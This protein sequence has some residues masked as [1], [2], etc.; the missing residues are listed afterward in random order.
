MLTQKI[1]LPRH[2]LKIAAAAG[3]MTATA[4]PVQAEQWRGWNIQPPGY[5]NTVALETFASE[6]SERTEGR[7]EPKVYNNGVLGAQPDAI[8]QTRNGALDFGNFN[9]GPMGPMVPAA[10]VLSLPF[11]F[12]S[13]ESMYKL[14]D[15][16]IGQRFANAMKDQGL[17]ALGWFGAGSRSLYNSDHPIE[18]P[19]DLK[20]MKIR[21]MNND[22][23]VD[24][25][26]ALGGNAT[27]MAASEVYQSLTTGVIDGAENNIPTY[28][29]SGHYE[30]ANYFSL[31]NH[32]VIPECLCVAKSSWDELSEQDRNSVKAAAELAV[33][34]QRKLWEERTTAGRKKV[35]DAGAKI[36][37]VSNKAAF[38]K[39]MKPVYDDFLESHPDL[40]SLVEDIQMAQTQ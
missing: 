3:L 40:A 16:E 25:I 1:L 32:L 15:G 14:M 36:N 24:M 5:P 21:V 31:T 10:N 4:F 19:E 9:M 11:I 23:Y 6:V 33:T 38:Q 22:L 34:E 39:L 13:E 8:E 2:S 20:G 27:P 28:E 12:N 37:E 17:I 30:V 7:I 26:E 18:A 29:A 35:L